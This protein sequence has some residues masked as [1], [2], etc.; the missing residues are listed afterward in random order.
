M[1]IEKKE[2]EN[3]FQIKLVNIINGE[4]S[5]VF[6]YLN[7]FD[8]SDY[9]IRL[10][11][12][13][14]EIE[15]TVYRHHKKDSKIEKLI[16][17]RGDRK[18]FAKL[19]AKIDLKE[20]IELWIFINTNTFQSHPTLNVESENMP[21]KITNI[22]NNEYHSTFYYIDKF[23]ISEHMI[24]LWEKWKEIEIIIYKRYKKESL[25]KILTYKGD[26]KYFVKL[27]A[28]VELNNCTEIRIYI[29]S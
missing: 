26:R 22:L 15:L 7:K 12:K 25:Q 29:S 1:E 13:W 2:D 11:E 9:M 10:W 23:D 4:Y 27:D 6:F 5:S 3:T 19:D 21:V 8:I 16:G 24:E 17:Y 20:N 28:Q 18:F 14:K